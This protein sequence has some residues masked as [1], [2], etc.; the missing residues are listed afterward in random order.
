MKKGDLAESPVLSFLCGYMIQHLFSV[1][2]GSKGAGTGL[3]VSLRWV[4]F[5]SRSTG[6]RST[7]GTVPWIYW[8]Q[9]YW[10]YSASRLYYSIP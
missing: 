10:R 8:V 2:S 9:E 7:A 5:P 6:Y 1:P 3:W 4:S